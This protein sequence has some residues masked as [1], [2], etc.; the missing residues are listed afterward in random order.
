MTKLERASKI[1]FEII[2][3]GKQLIKDYGTNFPDISSSDYL[4]TPSVKNKYVACGKDYRNQTL[5]HIVGPN[6][7]IICSI[8][9]KIVNR[10]GKEI[11][12]CWGLKHIHSTL[13]KIADG[14]YPHY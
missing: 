3:L 12:C 6:S 8:S 4:R 2:T 14:L 13:N 10:N 9:D 5:V 1:K 11:T 7:N